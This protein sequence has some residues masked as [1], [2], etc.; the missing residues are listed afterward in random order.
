MNTLHDKQQKLV[1]ILLNNIY[2]QD[3]PLNFLFTEF[4]VFR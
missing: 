1:L 2:I 4:H 3:M